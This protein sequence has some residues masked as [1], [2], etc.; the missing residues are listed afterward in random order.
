[1]RIAMLLAAAAASLSL[2]A[3]AAPQGENPGRVD[4][5]GAQPKPMS[6]FAFRSAQ[7]EYLLDDGRILAVTGQRAG[8]GRTLYADFGDGP[9]E[10]VALGRNRYAARDWDLQLR[11]VTAEGQRHAD[12]VHVSTSAGR[13]VALAKR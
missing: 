12:T 10:L 6:A 2:T 5:V 13:P 11:F 3:A 4:V 7:G 1:M 9:R 8:N